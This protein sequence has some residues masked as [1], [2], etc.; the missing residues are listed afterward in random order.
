[1][2]LCLVL[3]ST[4][5]ALAWAFADVLVVSKLLAFSAVVNGAGGSVLCCFE[6]RGEEIQSFVDNS[7]GGLCSINSNDNGGVSFALSLCG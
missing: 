1:M 6:E 3:L 7:L 2:V 4:Q 5:S